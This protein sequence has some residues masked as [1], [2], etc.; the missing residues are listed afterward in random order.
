MGEK[1]IKPT[2]DKRIRRAQ[3]QMV[4]NEALGEA[5]DESAASELLSLGLNSAA[6]IASSTEG[7]D[8]GAA[9]LSMADR[10]KALRKLMRHLAR[11]LG[12]ASDLD[13]EG[14]QW[15][16]ESVQRKSDFV[17]RRGFEFSVFRGSYGAFISKARLPGGSLPACAKCL[18]SKRKRTTSNNCR[19]EIKYIP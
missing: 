17:I 19:S 8:E 7:M 5:L 14:R 11:L 18:K 16:W 4:G 1:G 12:E 6:G 2:I 15:L 9:E 13:A 3:E 10:L